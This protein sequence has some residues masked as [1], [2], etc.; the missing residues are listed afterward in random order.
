MTDRIGICGGCGAKF[1]IPATFQADKAKC[2]KC[3]GV[4]EISAAGAAAGAAAAASPKPAAKSPAAKKPAGRSSRAGSSSRAS[5][6]GK[7]RAGASSKAGSSRG[8]SSR[9]GASSRSGGGRSRGGRGEREPKK[10]NTMLY[11]GIGGGVVLVGIL[12][13]VLLGGDDEKGTEDTANVAAA[14][15]TPDTPVAEPVVEPETPIADETPVDDAPVEPEAAPEP[16]PEPVEP[17][18]VEPLSPILAHDPIPNP[19]MD[20][21]EWQALQ[22][23]VSKAFIE[24]VRPKQRKE[25]RGKLT[26]AEAA[27]I[28]ALINGLI[29]LDISQER[30]LVNAGN[31]VLGIQSTSLDLIKIPLRLDILDIEANQDFNVKTVRSLFKYWEKYEGPD[32]LA[33]FSDKLQTQREKISEMPDDW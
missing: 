1:K 30:D 9:A 14:N 5:S 24:S 27:A 20:E 32:G 25:A 18:V 2:N 3:G 31:I 26:D 21:G 23:A 33:K 6:R 13:F 8:G 19:G 17:E 29:G 7:S 4:V 16:D 12:G 28:P 15:T 11:A 10:D 22:E